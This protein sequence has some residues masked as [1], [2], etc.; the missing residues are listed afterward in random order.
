MPQIAVNTGCNTNN[1]QGFCTN[2]EVFILDEGIEM[3]PIEQTA[4]N[5][6]YFLGVCQVSTDEDKIASF[7]ASAC[8]QHFTRFG[9]RGGRTLQLAKFELIKQVNHDLLLIYLD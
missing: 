7:K 9:E 2:A 6:N 5:R 8:R 1:K 3:M 4:L